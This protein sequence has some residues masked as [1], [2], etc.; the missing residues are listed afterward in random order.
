LWDKRTWVMEHP[1]RYSRTVLK[2]AKSGKEAYTKE[3]NTFFV[4]VDG[5]AQ[6]FLCFGD[7]VE[8]RVF[9]KFAKWESV[10]VEPKDYRTRWMYARKYG[11]S[12]GCICIPNDLLNS[13][14]PWLSG[15]TERSQELLLDFESLYRGVLFGSALAMLA[16]SN[17]SR[18]NELLQVSMNKERRITR[19]E[20]V[21]LLGDDSLPQTGENGQPLTKEV[22]LHFQYLLPKG[23][24]TEEE[25][26]LFPLSK[27]A[28]R[29]LE[30]IKQM[31]KDRHGEIPVVAL[32]R[33]NA[34]REHLKPERYIF[35][36]NPL[37]E[38]PYE[39]IGSSDVQTLLRLTLHGLDLY[40]VEGQPIRV[41]VH[42]L[43]ADTLIAFF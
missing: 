29:L 43:R 41:G 12:N 11:F 17:G 39:T 28:L 37:S 14:D 13:G 32:T 25:R 5:A 24:K 33:S 40:T 19:T 18:M 23:A 8:Q 31:L 20:R 16:L 34:K 9:R 10:E 4:Q 22:K 35:Q 38:E 6:D 42:V 7:L 36:W 15:T 27:E 26:Q 3:N 30:K 21:L 2:Y 1:D